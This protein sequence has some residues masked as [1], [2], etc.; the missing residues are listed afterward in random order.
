MNI[1]IIPARKGSKRIKNKNIRI[2]N[3]KPLIY[4][5]IKASLNSKLFDKIIISS[6]SKKILEIGSKYGAENL[7]L[8]EK[9]YAN[10]HMGLADV[11]KYEIDRLQNNQNIK[12][13]NVCLI[14]ATSLMLEKNDLVK[15]FKIFNK[16]KRKFCMAVTKNNNSIYKSFN[17]NKSNL[18]MLFNKNHKKRS[19]D[20]ISTYREAG[21]FCWGKVE[22]WQKKEVIF[23][24]NTLPYILPHFKSIDIDEIEDLKMAKIIFKNKNFF[25]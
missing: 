11:I 2:I 5:P 22:S 3:T 17:I 1:A 14:F 18:K 7:G 8:R 15:S 25:K 16:S 23:S 10:D 24:S 21:Q 20:L 9:V 6:D 12:V 13:K 4:Y 19:Q